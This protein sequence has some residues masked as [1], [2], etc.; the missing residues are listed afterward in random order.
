MMFMQLLIYVSCPVKN[1]GGYG[2]N[3]YCLSSDSSDFIRCM[4]SYHNNNSE[5]P[6]KKRNHLKA[7]KLK[8]GSGIRKLK[9]ILSFSSN[10]ELSNLQDLFSQSHWLLRN[11]KELECDH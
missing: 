5:R 2:R 3:R 1:S 11:F 7:G 9:R 6:S 4:L 8:E 10:I